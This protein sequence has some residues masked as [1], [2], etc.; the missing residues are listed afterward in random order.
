MPGD[1]VEDL[2]HI[3][4]LVHQVGADN[5]IE[6]GVEIEIMG[7]GF[8]ELE[9]RMTLPRPRNHSGREVE[10]DSRRRLQR[11]QKIPLP[12]ADFEDPHTGRDQKPVNFGQPALISPPA[13]QPLLHLRREP[14]PI[15]TTLSG[16]CRLLLLFGRHLAYY[17]S[18][19]PDRSRSATGC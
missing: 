6:L 4:D 15:E 16:I 5:V 10:T 2:L 13:R 11:R 7:I 12:T 8:D 19:A 14:V 3:P 18:D 17:G 1:G 9:M